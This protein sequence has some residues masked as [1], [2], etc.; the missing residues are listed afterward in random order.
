MVDLHLDIDAY[1]K[2]QEHEVCPAD[3]AGLGVL[4]RIV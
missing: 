2:L 3:V 1:L 4:E